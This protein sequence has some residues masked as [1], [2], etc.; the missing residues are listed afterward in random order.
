MESRHCMSRAIENSFLKRISGGAVSWLQVSDNRC[1]ADVI[2]FVDA[3][4]LV[5]RGLFAISGVEFA[6]LGEISA[7]NTICPL[8]FQEPVEPRPAG[9]QVRSLVTG[10]SVSEVIARWA[11]LAARTIPRT[12]RHSCGLS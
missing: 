7:G 6:R 4:D 12:N 3:G 10:P 8:K 9:L 5:S 11:G 2:S 1:S